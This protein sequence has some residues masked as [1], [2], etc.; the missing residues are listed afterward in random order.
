[1]IDTSLWTQTTT[2]RPCPL[3]GAE[4]RNV[5]SRR[6]QHGLDLV[7]VIC[8]KC[9]FVST[10]PM[11]PRET[12]ERF[13]QDAYADYYGHITPKPDGSRLKSEPLSLTAKFN[14]IGQ[15][16]SLAGC[17]LL[18]PCRCCTSGATLSVPAVVDRC[19]AGSAGLGLAPAMT[20]R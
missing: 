16:R 14:R 5:V 15:T 19:G 8:S 13:Y 2:P 12:Y 4:E 9:S 1:M 3:C 18:R 10:N 20:R 17:R 7:T 11:P 6:M